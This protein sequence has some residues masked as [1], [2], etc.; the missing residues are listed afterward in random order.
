MNALDF[1]HHWKRPCA[2]SVSVSTTPWWPA[3][4]PVT[5]PAPP[6]PPQRVIPPSSLSAQDPV[7]HC[8]FPPNMSSTS[9]QPV[10]PVCPSAAPMSPASCLA[11]LR[12]AASACYPAHRCFSSCSCPLPPPPLG[13]PL[14]IRLQSRRPPPSCSA[15]AGATMSIESYGHSQYTPSLRVRP[16][17]TVVRPIHP[18]P[19]RSSSAESRRHP[20]ADSLLRSASQRSGCDMLPAGHPPRGV[21][22]G[23]CGD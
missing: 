18:Q 8:T 12:A 10:G 20:E 21:M 23:C 1:C 6:L 13:S 4:I 7:G 3:V 16:A 14:T 9:A 5:P 11:R 2:Q 19:H 15:L 22:C 17:D